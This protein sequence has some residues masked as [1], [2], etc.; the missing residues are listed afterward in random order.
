MFGKVSIDSVWNES[1]FS[2][3]SL[4]FV[5]LVP[6]RRKQKRN[7]APRPRSAELQAQI[8]ASEAEREAKQAELE[9]DREFLRELGVNPEE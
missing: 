9:A 4:P 5:V 7:S 1:A 3:S 6:A 2:L 8:R